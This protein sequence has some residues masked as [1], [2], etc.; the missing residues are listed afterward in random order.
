MLTRTTKRYVI[1]L[2]IVV[3]LVALY[4]VAGFWAVP[5]FLRSGLTD[6]VSTHYKRKLSL[7]EIRFNPYT[8]TLDVA[9][10]SLPD[11]DGEPMLAFGRLHVDLEIISLLRLGPSFHEIVLERPLVRTVVR[12]DGS[13]NLADLGKG[14]ASAPAATPPPKPSEPM[15]LFIDRFAVIAGGGTFEDLSH[16]TPFRAEFKPI[17]FELR[18]FSTRA[19]PNSGDSNEYSLTAASTEGE[20]L[21]WNGVFL[22]EPLSSHGTFAVTDLHATTIWSYLQEPLPMDIRSGVIAVK[23][24]YNFDIAGDA[25]AIKIDVHDTTVTDLKLRPRQGTTDYVVLDKLDVQETKVDLNKRA[26]DIG[27]V[28]LTGGEVN[29]WLS[30]QGQLNL[31][32]LTTPAGGAGGKAVPPA[33]AT[34]PRAAAPAGDSATAPHAA[35]PAGDSAT[36]P[37]AVAPAG[38]SAAAPGATPP[39]ATPA[40]ATPPPAWVIT[41]P[42]ITVDGFKVAAED[43]QLTPALAVVLDKINMHVAGYNTT[44]AAHL[45]VTAQTTIN[46]SSTLNATA[47]LSPSGGDVTAHVDLAQFDLAMLQPFI[48]QQTAMTLQSG[49]L[50]TQL[51]IKKAADGTLSV[52]GDAGVA[53][54]RTVD[55]LKQSFIKWK[56]LRVAGIDY[57]SQPASLKIASITAHEPYARVIIAPDRTVNVQVVLAGP[58][59]G[60]PSLATQLGEAN[61][62]AGGVTVAGVK[63]GSPAAQ[64]EVKDIKAKAAADASGKA[65]DAT[66]SASNSNTKAT[67]AAA[68]AS[69]A[70]TKAAD[71]AAAASGAN[72]KATDATAAATDA[73]SKAA[74]ATSSVPAAAADAKANLASAGASA[75]AAA[76]DANAK[77]ANAAASASAATADANANGGNTRATAK[78]SR[79][80]RKP[81]ASPAGAAASASAQP[82][83]PVMP[84]AIGTVRVIDGSVNYADFWIKPNFAVGIQSLNGSIDGLSSDPKSRAKVKL[85]GKVDRYAPVSI[86][87]QLNLLAATV[88]SDIKMNFKGLE[89]TTMT[90]YSGHF[91]GYKIDKGKL[92]V[93][94]SYKVDQRKLAAEQ[95][96]VIDQLQLGEAV[97][98]PDAVHLPLKLAVALLKDRNGVIDLPLPITGSLDDPQFKVGPIIWHALINLLEKAV[99]APFAALGRLFGG[100][101]EDMKFIDFPPGSA[102][103]DGPSKEKLE[104]LTKALQEHTQ[105]QLDVPI[106]YSQDIDG[107]V[108]AKQKLNQKLVARAHGDKSTKKPVAQASGK[109]SSNKQNADAA[110]S[111]ATAASAAASPGA[112]PS[113][114]A[115]QV[116]TPLGATP[117]GAATPGAPPQA[118]S[119]DASQPASQ[120]PEP[121][122]P[123]LANPLEHY[124]LLLAEYQA[125]LGKDADLPATAAAIQSAKNK[126]DAPPVE[127]AIPELEDAIAGQIGVSD[128]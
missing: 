87:G 124:R 79:H 47:Q 52:K 95:H 107:P 123:A 96:F 26:V 20:R 7:G 18:K 56:D 78:G 108:L 59:K 71:A 126:K 24:E 63:G 82:A 22:L 51:D 102:E 2:S 49:R 64:A 122:D 57:N 42:D 21:D 113:Q 101:G 111:A 69:N 68:A 65:T 121:L 14:F 77:L 53:G 104:S 6:F 80:S 15:R 110:Q 73:N 44:P 28:S 91:A 76:A 55:E 116:A 32:E 25:P 38:D 128:L 100:H 46:G 119:A 10:L 86:N 85:E 45:D 98:S 50:A 92:S 67:D 5:H 94:L 115:A 48:A 33:A 8:F 23:G 29:A 39:P 88:Y 99:T 112:A 12:R 9:D 27:K 41:A 72:T 4:T 40:S 58:S 60:A 30:P 74:N 114:G 1:A 120:P 62:K 61:T 35:A 127:T 17:A 70:N 19:K 37:G 83:A 31:L 13:L 117:P 16:A 125:E 103:L 89:L 105:L 97:D 93:D 84:M 34:A 36:A 54:L 90:P 118:A 109:Q 75:T 43:R 3:F 66:A 81:R 11:S 106:A